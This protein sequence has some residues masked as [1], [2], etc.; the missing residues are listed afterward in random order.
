MLFIWSPADLISYPMFEGRSIVVP[1]FTSLSRKIIIILIRNSS[2]LKRSDKHTFKALVLKLL[3]G[4]YNVPLHSSNS[5]FQS[6]FSI[7]QF[8]GWHLLLLPSSHGPI[9]PLGHQMHFPPNGPASEYQ[10]IVDKHSERSNILMHSPML[11]GV[12]QFSSEEPKR[13]IT[14]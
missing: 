9:E 14:N 2:Y 7:R 4:K 1:I 11:G 13:S 6:P 12:I 10:L 3:L 5:D 8:F